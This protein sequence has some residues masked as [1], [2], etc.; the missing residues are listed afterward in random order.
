M[1]ARDT[2][3]PVRD[4]RVSLNPEL[5]TSRINCCEIISL[6]LVILRTAFVYGPYVNYGGQFVFLSQL[7]AFM[8]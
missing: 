7:E 8:E 4:P 1:V 5:P 6:N 2:E 3:N